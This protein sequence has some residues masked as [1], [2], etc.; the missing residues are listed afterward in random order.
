MRRSDIP[1]SQL[2]NQCQKNAEKNVTSRLIEN[3]QIDGM[4]HMNAEHWALVK[5]NHSRKLFCR[6]ISFFFFHILKVKNRLGD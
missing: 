3:I 4:S 6:Y 5:E 2:L 1:P